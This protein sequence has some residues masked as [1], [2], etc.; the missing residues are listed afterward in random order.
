MIEEEKAKAFEDQT[1]VQGSCLRRR[2]PTSSPFRSEDF[3]NVNGPRLFFA[4]F[5]W[6][7]QKKEECE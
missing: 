5:F 6:A 1:L 7:M 3:R 2:S 4:S